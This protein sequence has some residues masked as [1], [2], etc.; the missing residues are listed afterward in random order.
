MNQS[1]KNTMLKSFIVM[2]LAF[3]ISAYL[4]KYTELLNSNTSWYF[5]L[6][7]ALAFFV[8]YI[9]F[10]LST[11]KS[12]ASNFNTQ[13]SALFGIKFFSY[14]IIAVIFIVLEK[15]KA[16]RLIFII[17]L[18]PIYMINTAILLRGILNYQK[19]ISN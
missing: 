5:L 13:V 3:F 11:G 17:Y 10:E 19:T 16:Q 12:M 2:I 8:N 4:Y 7:P 9:A 18:F 15:E 14:L 1:K 6:V